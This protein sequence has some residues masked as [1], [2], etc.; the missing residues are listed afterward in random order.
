MT[1]P[2]KIGYTSL[3]YILEQMP[4]MKNVNNQLSLQQTQ[5]ENELKRLQKEFQDKYVAYEKGALQMSD[6]IR[7]DKETELK[8]LQARI[9]EFARSADEGIQKKNNELLAPLLQK[10]QTAIDAVATENGYTYIFSTDS[11]ANALP[12]LLFAPKDYDITNLVLTKL[13]ISLA[14]VPATNGTTT[15]R[16][17]GPPKTPAKPAPPKKK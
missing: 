3:Q 12:N 7:K 13:G 9:Q 1:A 10:A 2:L 6:V 11:G 5:A 14:A 15:P 8:A 16:P 4:E 17:S